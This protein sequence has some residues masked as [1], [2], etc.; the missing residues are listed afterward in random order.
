M[1]Q[2]RLCVLVTGETVELVR[3][4]FG[5][6]QQFFERAIGDRWTGGYEAIDARTDDPA[7]ALDPGYAAV[8][9]TGSPSSVTERAPWMLRAEEALRAL[10]DRE[11]PLLGVCFGHQLLASALGG[12]VR[13]NPAGRRLGTH[14][15]RVRAEDDALFAG[16]DREL[17]VNVSH[18][19]HVA[20]RPTRG[21]I[22]H[23]AETDHDS[24]HA[25][26]AGNRAWGVQFHPEFSDEITRGYVHARRALLVRAGLDPDAIL[27]R[28]E[29]TPAG[30]RLLENF[31]AIV[32]R[33][34]DAAR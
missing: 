8:I 26:R 31:V 5:E 2:R 6:F 33:E 3:E 25:F 17:R 16:L 28:I 14:L 30:P 18:E 20:V 27:A 29:A 11:K 21:A 22:A 13:R 9:V 23:L 15:V 32:E 34:G 10:V 4:R 1:S 19:D 7:R 24:F 12:E